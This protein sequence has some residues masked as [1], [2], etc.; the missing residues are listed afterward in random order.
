MRFATR[1]LTLFLAGLALLPAAATTYGVHLSAAATPPLSEAFGTETG[2]LLWALGSPAPGL[3][4]A[5]PASSTGLFTPPSLHAALAS[6]PP[7][8][9][10]PLLSVFPNPARGLLTVQLTAQHGPDYK[11]RLS[12]VLGR[13]V[14]LLPLPLATAT[15]GLPLDVTGLPAGLYFC[16]LLV[17]DKAVSTNRLTLL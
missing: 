15:T 10:A 13:E 2:S 16:S 7:Q 9:G 5:R 12:N 17:N 14:R 6:M 8:S 11:M 3:T 1:L 4:F